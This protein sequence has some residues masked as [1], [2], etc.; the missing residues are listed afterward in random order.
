M[1]RVLLAVLIFGF[2][3][4]C[5]DSSSTAPSP[6][7][8]NVT[9]TWSGDLAVQGQTGRMTWTLTQSGTS[10]T[11]PV[12]VGLPNG[13]VLLNGTLSGTLNGTA[14]TYSIDVAPGGIPT[15]PSC[16]GRFDGT[17]TVT[18]GSPSTMTGSYSVATS[19]CTTGFTSG[20]F[21]LTR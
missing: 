1:R 2:V 12:L 17:T 9:G 10:V 19:T 3:T 6:S 13:V 21:T 15:Q 8:L 14:L 5:S 20:N 11:G 4:G 16:T 18:Q 7:S